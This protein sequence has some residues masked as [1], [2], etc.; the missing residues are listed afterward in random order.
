[1]MM[2]APIVPGSIAR[3]FV[4]ASGSN[5]FGHG[6]ISVSVIP[7]ATTPYYNSSAVDW[8]HFRD[9]RWQL[10]LVCPQYDTICNSLRRPPVVEYPLRS[11]QSH[12]LIG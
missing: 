11:R 1:M 4:A 8:Y 7:N 3:G 12:V 10:S 9:G 6:V 5:V 2:S